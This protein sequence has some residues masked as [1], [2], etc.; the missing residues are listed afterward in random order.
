VFEYV[1]S[2]ADDRD[3]FTKN[4]YLHV[5]LPEDG[6]AG[7]ARLVNWDSDAVF[8]NNWDGK[9]IDADNTDWYGWDAFAPR[10]LSV[11]AWRTRYLN[12]FRYSLLTIMRPVILKAR[13]ERVA[14][15]LRQHAVKD[16]REWGR[17]MDFDDEVM[18]LKQNIGLRYNTM[19][20]VTK[21]LD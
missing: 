18:R 21:Y 3:A 15:V 14:S 8:G 1:R 4:Y 16:L 19:V 13:A 9:V 20:M 5:P 6:G 2:F 12:E 17:N 7:R 11:P 10:F